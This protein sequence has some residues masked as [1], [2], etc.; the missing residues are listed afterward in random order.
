MWKEFKAFAMR[1]NVIDLAVGVII[2]SAFTGIVNSLVNDI[3]MPPI[4]MLL[5]GVD[6]KDLFISLDGVDYP[7]L[8]AAQEAGGAT[9]NYGAFINNVL[10]FLIVAFVIFLV[11][12]QINKIRKRMEK[13]DAAKAEAKAKDTRECPQC[14]SE[15]PIKAKRCKY[16]TSVVEAKSES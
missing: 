16:C 3:I 5:K 8:A 12:R 4:G 10:N 15:I 6:F 13:Q 9:W 2:G 1:G 7:S 11:V 14:L